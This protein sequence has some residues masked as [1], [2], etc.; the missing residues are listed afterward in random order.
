[1]TTEKKTDVRRVLEQAKTN[2]EACPHYRAGLCN[3]WKRMQGGPSTSPYMFTG[4]QY[5]NC[6]AFQEH[7]RL[8]QKAK[9]S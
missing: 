7:T 8:V 4:S 1:M 3:A 2:P 9:Y 5:L 6:Y